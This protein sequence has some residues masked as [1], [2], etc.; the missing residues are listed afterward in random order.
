MVSLK[1]TPFLARG[2]IRSKDEINWEL[3]LPGN[4]VNPPS[5]PPPI[6]ITG[7]TSP[8][9]EQQTPNLL[10]AC[11]RGFTGR[12]ERDTPAVSRTRPGTSEQRAV[13]NLRVA[14]ESLQKT[15]ES[16]SWKCPPLTR[17]R[18]SSCWIPTPI[19]LNASIAALVS[20][21]LSGFIIRLSP[22]DRAA[23]TKPRIV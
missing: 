1:V 4:S 11:T 10:S 13:I 18:F 9:L 17:H 6:T 12:L 7:V 15:S 21:E 8:W 23:H 16:G 2:D 20:S 5:S 3:T 19:L 22:R 14:A